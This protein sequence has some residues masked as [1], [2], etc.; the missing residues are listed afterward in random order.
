MKL[1]IATP[2]Y[3][4]EIGG[5]ATYAKLLF[6]GLPGRGIEVELVKFNEVRYLPKIIRHY[7]YYRHVLKAARNADVVLALDPVSV[8]L[9]AMRAAQ[10]A[11][12]PFVVKIVGDYAWEQGQQRFGVTENLDTFVKNEQESFFVRR[13]QKIQTYVA[14]NAA[15]VIVPSPYLQDIVVA[16]G[17]PRGK[18]AVI[19]NGIDLPTHIPVPERK[20]GEFLIV[21]AGRRVPWKG[22]EAIERVARGHDRWR[23]FIASGLPRVEALGWMKAADVFVLNSRYEGFPHAL[24]EAMTLGTPVIATDARFHRTLLT[25][26]ETGLLVPPGD[27]GALERALADV[28]HNTAAAQ[29]RADAARRRMDEFSLPHMLESTAYF[30]KQIV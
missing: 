10:K 16:W 25:H 6:D 4:P 5:P 27:D 23:V 29:A 28:A 20:E 14:K 3:P 22:F 12:K 30:L 2:L 26:E 8:G 18:I 7:V 17:I 19:Y 11:G 21:S 9:P 15:Q 24:I 13:L 1:V